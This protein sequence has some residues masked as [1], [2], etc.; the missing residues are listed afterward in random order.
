MKT[1][2]RLGV[3]TGAMLWAMGAASVSVAAGD[4]APQINSDNGVH[5]VPTEPVGSTSLAPP[6][7]TLKVARAMKIESGEQAKPEAAPPPER[8]GLQVAKSAPAPQP[9]PDAG[10]G[11]ETA[12]AAAPTQVASQTA[13]APPVAAASTPAPVADAGPAPAAAPVQVAAQTVAAPAEAS[14]PAPA[15]APAPAPVQDTQAPAVVAPPAQLAE[16]D[17]SGPGPEELRAYGHTEPALA[18]A[19]PE[20][21]GSAVL[22]P[23]RDD[24][25]DAPEPG[26]QQHV[27]FPMRSAEAA[28]AFDSYMQRAGRIDAGLTSGAQVKSAL[29][30][31]SAYDAHQL[32][33]GMI[34]YGAIA[35]LQSPRFV[36]A[37][38]DA[39]ANDRAR[40]E[41]ILQILDDPGSAT[42][43]PGAEDAASL[44]D[45][46]ILQEAR[47]VV[48]AGRALKQASYDVQHAGWSS[49][50]VADPDGRLARAKAAS[51]GRIAAHDGDVARLLTQVSTMK[52]SGPGRGSFTQVTERSVALAALAV[53]DGAGGDNADRLGSVIS[54]DFSAQCL[55]MAKLNLF[56]CLSVAGPEY[57]DVY[58]LGQHAVLD[59]GQCVAA[60]AS[61]T[62]RMLMSALPRRFED[63]SRVMVPTAGMSRAP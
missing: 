22:Q 3:A 46:A 29:E 6:G 53:L 15:A 34:A 55:K 60:A 57:E 52:A 31:A 40:R 21:P 43:I 63:D 23:V 37:V 39:A 45:S 18:Q 14:T 20:G 32:E 26:L 49:A 56:Q 9:I 27:A 59:T 61:P 54:E 13:A 30:T 17:A 19:G 48:S 4:Q 2:L 10:P 42:Q 5:A 28:A 38:M 1:G 41:L 50:K 36:Y 58:C 44:A 62:E 35:A 33:E 16:A 24:H 51:A 8:L 11:P 12:P 25:R 47:P 7:G